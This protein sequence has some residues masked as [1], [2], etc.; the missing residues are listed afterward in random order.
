MLVSHISTYIYNPPDSSKWLYT[1][2]ILTEHVGNQI[3][4]QTLQLDMLKQ[5][6]VASTSKGAEFM[7]SL[8]L[9]THS[10]E[11]AYTRARMS[12]MRSPYTADQFKQTKHAYI[13]IY[14]YTQKKHPN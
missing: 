8:C 14:I 11:L 4:L 2:T 3:V 10:L 6:L 1:L 5:L 13:C 7:K 12:Y 9:K